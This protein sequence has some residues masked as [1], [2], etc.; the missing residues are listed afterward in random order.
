MNDLHTLKVDRYGNLDMQHY[1][2]EARRL[3]SAHNASLLASLKRRLSAKIQA[4]LFKS[5]QVPATHP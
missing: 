3:R 1:L 4:H 2:R 5:I